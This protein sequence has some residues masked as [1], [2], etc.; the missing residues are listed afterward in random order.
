M[1]FK[2]FKL[3][4]K[5]SNREIQGAGRE[6]VIR[7]TIEKYLKQMPIEA[8]KKLVNLVEINEVTAEQNI[9]NATSKDECEYWE[10]FLQQCIREE[11]EVFRMENIIEVQ[12]DEAGQ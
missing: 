1:T 2:K 12:D 7:W 5:V 11:E 4:R 10:Q 9:K 6:I 8:L 3:E